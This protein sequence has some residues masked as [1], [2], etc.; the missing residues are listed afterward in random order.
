[1]NR[2]ACPTERVLPLCQG[3]RHSQM[4]SKRAGVPAIKVPPLLK[5]R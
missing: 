1:M 4:P 3:L 5:E 2:T